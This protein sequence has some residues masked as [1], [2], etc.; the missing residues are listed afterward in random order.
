MMKKDAT[1]APVAVVGGASTKLLAN[2]DESLLNDSMTTVP[3]KLDF[4]FADLET[5][6][7]GEEAAAAQPLMPP[8]A[9]VMGGKRS[10]RVAT[11]TLMM[12]MR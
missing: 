10:A 5:P 7:T 8:P 4:M 1:T 11:S 9:P 6:Q 2:V 3:K 12:A